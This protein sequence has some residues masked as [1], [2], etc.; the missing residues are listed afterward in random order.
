[1]AEHL[2]D[3]QMLDVFL[4]ETLDQNTMAHLADC[5][6]CKSEIAATKSGLEGFNELGANWAETEAVR[7]I[8][9]RSRFAL[10][11]GI[12]AGT[13]W[14]MTALTAAALI[15]FVVSQW[16]HL[17]TRLVNANRDQ[18]T[19][20]EI[21]RDNQWMAAMDRDLR[22]GPDSAG[23]PTAVLQSARTSAKRHGTKV[24]SN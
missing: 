16:G 22:Y 19:T 21:Q 20:A 4:G 2:T 5:A 7:K 23:Y 6:I 3:E 1:M 18:P 10:R 8:R 13:A 9:V 11:T 24:V 14:S 12:G 17:Q 15:V